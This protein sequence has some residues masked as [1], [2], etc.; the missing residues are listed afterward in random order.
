MSNDGSGASGEMLEK[1]DFGEGEKGL[2]DRW[3]EE[4]KQS[5]RELLDK[6]FVKNGTKALQVLSNQKV[7]DAAGIDVQYNIYWSYMQ[8]MKEIIYARAPQPV[9]KP[10]P[11]VKGRPATKACSMMEDNLR[12]F[13]TDRDCRFWPRS[14]MMVFDFMSVGRGV[15]WPRLV[16]EEGEPNKITLEPGEVPPEDAKVQKDKKSKQLFYMAPNILSERVEVD[17]VHWKDYRES[18]ARTQEEVRWKAKRSFLTKETMTELVGKEI[19]DEISYQTKFG[20]EGNADEF[21]HQ[22]YGRAEVWE[23]HDG[24]ERKIIWISPGYDKKVLKEQPDK[25]GLKDFYSTPAPLVASVTNESTIPTCDYKIYGFLVDKINELTVRIGKIISAVKVVVAYN[26]EISGMKDMFVSVDTSVIPVDDWAAF[27]EAGGFEGVISALPIDIFVKGIEG[28]E[29]QRGRY[30]QDFEEITGWSEIRQADGKTAK[31]KQK[32]G[33]F[34]NVRISGRQEAV[35]DYLCD[36]MVVMAEI[37]GKHFSPESI[38]RYAGTDL[39]ELQAAANPPM[40]PMPAPMPQGAPPGA[41]QDPNQPPAPQGPP[42]PPMVDPATL[43]EF[44]DTMAAIQLLKDDFRRNFTLEIQTDST[45]AV[46]ERL[47]K[48]DRI[49]FSNMATQFFQSFTNMADKAPQFIEPAS[50]IFLFC[51]DAFRSARP[52]EDAMKDAVAKWQ[53]A[54]ANPPPP[55]PD[56]M[57]AK[58]QSDQQIAEQKLQFEQGK[59]GAIQQ[60]E[61][62]KS[63]QEY[64]VHMDKLNESFQRAQLDREEAQKEFGIKMMTDMKKHQEEMDYKFQDLQAKL[65]IASKANDTQTTLAQIA[66]AENSREAIL[67]AHVELSKEG[68]KVDMEREIGQRDA[69]VTH[70]GI[71]TDALLK[72]HEISESKEKEASEEKSAAAAK[73]AP[74]PKIEVHVHMPK[75][76]KLARVD[77]DPMT[78]AMTPTYDEGEGAE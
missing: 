5:E 1:E 70:M 27:Q 57:I 68:M 11:G 67:G 52:I 74:S 53:K 48:R 22:V 9:I 77:T 35:Q 78:G 13:V 21:K 34:P 23:I 41:P 4:L 72:S 28:L 65:L 19:A 64:Q 71:L 29:N 76:K 39:Q 59:F 7:G 6:D 40:P 14:L 47:E 12:Y 42:P 37:I 56:P 2:Y 58:I 66:A 15:L 30:K 43:Q 50:E 32:D 49:E 26:S 55:P 17:Y 54:Q 62:Q 46:N 31:E 16:L 8:V 10:K 36:V 69:E 33:D 20:T 38:A 73:P 25:L 60:S 63:T 24:D 51:L 44:Q 45:I 75:G 18:V 61:Q 3:M